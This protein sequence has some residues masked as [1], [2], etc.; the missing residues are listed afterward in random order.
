MADTDT[1]QADDSQIENAKA[2]TAQ[3]AETQKNTREAQARQAAQ[4]AQDAVDAKNMRE[5]KSETA[6]A[7]KTAN[8]SYKPGTAEPAAGSVATVLG[9]AKTGMD[10]VPQ[11][12]AYGLTKGET[13]L[14][15]E[16][17]SE[18]RKVFKSRGESG[19]HKW[20]GK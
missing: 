15:A 10:K 3:T 20:S 9:G 12:G 5:N 19:Q 16:R 2:K 13:V 1:Y 6:G 14:P 4:G 18:Y 7:A 11:T 17:A 8:A